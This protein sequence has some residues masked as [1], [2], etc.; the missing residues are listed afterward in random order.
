M[1]VYTV[2]RLFFFFNK[3]FVGILDEKMQ[4]TYLAHSFSTTV[5]LLI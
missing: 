5:E 4:G 2:L 3:C 1:I